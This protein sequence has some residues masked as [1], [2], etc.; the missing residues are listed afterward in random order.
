MLFKKKRQN[1][2]HIATHINTEFALGRKQW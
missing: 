1:Q 2:D